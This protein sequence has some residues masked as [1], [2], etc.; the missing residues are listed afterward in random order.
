MP[1]HTLEQ[2]AQALQGCVACHATY[3]IAVSAP[4]P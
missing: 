2:L 3:A 4:T 1:S